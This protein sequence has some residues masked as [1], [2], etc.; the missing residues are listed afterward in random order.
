MYKLVIVEDERDVRRR[1]AGLIEKSGCNFEIVSEYETGIDAYDGIISDNPDLILTDIQIPYINGIELSKKIREIYPLVNIIIITGYSEFDYAKE[2]ANLGVIGFVNKPITLENI[3]ELLKKAEASLD[4][5]FLTGSNLDK[6][7]TFYNEN[8]P[9]IKENELLNLS[10]MTD[11]TLTFQQRL[12]ASNIKLDYP[13]FAM[14]VFDFDEMQDGDV[15]NN[16]LI[17]S[18]IRKLIAEELQD[19]CDIE[20]FN[21]YEK[22]CLIVKSHTSPDVT[23]LERRMERVV[24]RAAR[25]SDVPV[26]AGISSIFNNNKNFSAMVKEAGRALEYRNIMGGEKVFIFGNTQSPAITFSIDESL[27]KELG[28]I[29]HTQNA[30]AC[31]A[32]IDLIRESLRSSNNPLYYAATGILNVLIRNC[33]DLKGL[34]EYSGT[35][36]MLYKKL[37]EIK[38]EDE[39]YDY[40]KSL[41]HLVRKLNDGVIIDNV[42]QS[43]RIVNSYMEAHFCD[44]DISFGR[45]ARDVNFSVGYI[46]ALLKKKLNTSF[47]KKLTEMRMEK[48]KELLLNP[49]LKIIDIAEQLGYNDSY[50]FSHCFKKYVGVPPKEFRSNEQG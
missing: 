41:V 30:E 20:I 32:R 19:Y 23:E 40:L 17:S 48:A 38:T 35:P 33:D 5:K 43:L 37:F 14:C 4:N 18:F 49:S 46:S 26:S 21:R 16:D 44:P 42:E 25:F 10:K 31:I 34:Y 2:A 24:Q 39:I 15:E 9:V 11:V 22:I 36:D 1:L 28:Y 47:V 50:Y 6:L 7:T 3:Q 45:M 27:I 8:I 12:L 29:L 13:Y